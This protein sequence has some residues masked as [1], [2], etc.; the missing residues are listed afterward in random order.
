MPAPTPFKDLAGYMDKQ[1]IAC[2]E[3]K[4]TKIQEKIARGTGQY[5]DWAMQFS[6]I[7]DDSGTFHD[8]T[9]TDEN[10]F[11]QNGVQGKR[12]RAESQPQSKGGPAGVV[13]SVRH[14]DGKENRSIKVDNRAKITLLDGSTSSGGVQPPGTQGRGVSEQSRASVE[15]VR[16]HSTVDE[17]LDHQF[18]LFEAAWKRSKATEKE[19][20]ITFTV[21]DIRAF[22]NTIGSTFKGEYGCYAAPI[23]EKVQDW[24]TVKTGSGKLLGEMSESELA[25]IILKV[26]A[27]KATDEKTVK[28]SASLKKA[29]E[30]KRWAPLDVAKLAS[31]GL[32]GMMTRFFIIDLFKVAKKDT[33]AAS[34]ADITLEQWA[35]VFE[36]TDKLAKACEQEASAGGGGDEDCIPFASAFRSM[37]EIGL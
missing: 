26:I 5:G 25:L 1:V 32:D 4:I 15:S 36:N 31:D 22:T 37:G 29:M 18:R 33:D 9:I 28:A 27:S 20:G 7:Q 21:E 34:E 19:L 24:R 13:M 2:V 8:L 3:G 14:K 12:L 10:S 16:D 23:W 17:R 30:E 6:T 11:L 35:S